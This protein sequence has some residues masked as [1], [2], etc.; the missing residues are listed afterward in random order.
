MCRFWDVNLSDI[1]ERVKAVRGD[2]ADERFGLDAAT[3]E[4]LA[5]ECTH[6]IH[7]GGVVRMN[8][9]L[10][11]ARKTALDAARNICDLAEACRQNGILEKIEFV[12]TVGVAGRLPG[13]LPETWITEPRTFHNT[14]EQAK[15]EAEEFIADKVNEGLPVTV[16]RPSMVVGASKNRQDHPFPGLLPSLRVSIRQENLRGCAQICRS[17]A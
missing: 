10:Q 7:C 17:A 1:R 4:A 11:E 8:L 15:A 9:P 12:S 3:Y 6:I 5:N 13:L 16:H 14:Y 2:M